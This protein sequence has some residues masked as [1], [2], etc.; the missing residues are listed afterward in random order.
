M[1]PIPLEGDLERASTLFRRYQELIHNA[2]ILASHNNDS[3]STLWKDLWSTFVTQSAWKAKS[4]TLG[5]FNVSNTEAEL[6]ELQHKYNSSLFQLRRSQT[7][8]S[9]HW[10][11]QQGVCVDHL[12]EGTST[13]SMAGRGAFATRALSKGTIVAP[14]PMIHIPYDYRL[15]MYAL[16]RDGNGNKVVEEPKRVVGKQLLLNYCYGHAEST[17]LLC[18]Y[19]SDVNI[20]NHNRTLANVRLQWADATRGVHNASL[21]DQSVAHIY[22]NYNRVALSMEL[23][24]TRDIAKGEEIFLDYGDEWEAAWQHH[25]QSWRPHSDSYSAGHWNADKATRLRTVFEQLGYPYPPNIELKCDQAFLM[26]YKPIWQ[27]LLNEAN[28]SEALEAYRRW[29]TEMLA[30]CDVLRMRYDGHRVLYTTVIKRLDTPNFLK[31][32]NYELMVDVPREAFF[33][34]DQP[35]TSDTFLPNAFRHAIMIP[36]ELFPE[37]WKNRNISYDK[38]K[39]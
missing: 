3:S 7:A 24:A 17:M 36:D 33:F 13:L 11:E 39:D 22:A 12:R 6:N 26:E 19:G 15:D 32:E 2:S 21:L 27:P 34:V 31:N 29:T 1:G 28:S 37:A 4:R 16:T 5:A 8:R 9:Q 10:L 30:P 38:M 23:V 35:Y 18:P 25:V 14:M 20:I